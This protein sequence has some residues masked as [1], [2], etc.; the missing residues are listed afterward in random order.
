MS[1]RLIVKLCLFAGFLA[2][3]AIFLLRENLTKDYQDLKQALSISADNTA[4]NLS[5][6]RSASFGTQYK[7]EALKVEFG[8]VFAGFSRDDWQVMWKI[9]YGIRSED[10]LDNER[11]P[12]RSR[13]LTLDEIEEEL[14]ARF[15][16]P[17][18]Y[19]TAEHW[20]YFWK[21]LKISK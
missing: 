20:Q 4:Y 6:P 16:S 3:G 18:A 12:A 8:P 13:Q 14:K 9:I 11:L 5:P 21:I 2:A 17:F 10:N 19:F 1:R 15:Y 7:E